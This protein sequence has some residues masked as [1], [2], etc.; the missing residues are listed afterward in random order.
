M[1]MTPILA[2]KMRVLA[3]TN[4]TLHAE[5]TEGM[6]MSEREDLVRW[7]KELADPN[8]CLSVPKEAKDVIT[9]LI[10][11]IEEAKPREVATVEELDGLGD[12]A[13]IRTARGEY[14]EASKLVDGENL[15][16]TMGPVKVLRSPD[17]AAWHLPATVLHEGTRDE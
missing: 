9:K 12:G 2:A 8:W 6:K 7:A 16:R 10:A 4:P 11:A 15:W 14:R 5:I 17:L 3:E 13:L 1:S